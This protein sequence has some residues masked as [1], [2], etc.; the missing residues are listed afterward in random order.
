MIDLK[1]FLSAITQIEEEK[2]IPREKIIET[3][4]MALAA[5]YKKDYGQRG[6]IIRAKLDPE[7]GDFKLWQ[8]KIVV[9]ESM[10]KSEE[11]IEQE[12]K[13]GKVQEP[14]EF[15]SQE[16]DEELPKK[17]RFNEE[18]HIMIDEARTI[19]K[20]AKPADELIFDVQI[21]ED[22]GR[23]AAQ[24]AKQ[25]IIQRIREAER[26]AVYEEY[27][28]KADQIISGIV[29]RIEGS[30][31]FF[32]IGKTTGVM[33]PKDRM[34]NEH[35]RVGQ[36]LRL[37]LLAIEQGPKGAIIY[38][39]RSHPKMLSRLFELEV[40]EI[41]AETVIIKAIAREAGARSK[42]AVTS[43]EEGV[44]PIGSCV[45]QRGTRVTAVIQEL[46]GEKIDII[47]WHEDSEEFIAASLSPAKVLGVELDT[48]RARVMVSEDQ[49]SLAIGKDGQ[50]VRLAAKLTG[51]RIDIVSKETGEVEQG[52]KPAEG[53]ST[54]GEEEEPSGQEG[55]KKK[56]TIIK[57]KAIKKED[58]KGASAT[59][60]KESTKKKEEPKKK[61]SSAKE[62]GE[63]KPKKKI[64]KK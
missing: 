15:L 41:S 47:E 55:T 43:T 58:E 25:V 62:K 9:D 28:E 10:I 36:R 30:Y 8:V 53:E 22:F 26:E 56:K 5:A 27:A 49:L 31:V 29:Q 64:K 44:D 18:K 54:S 51:W 63:K 20:K 37:Y 35:Y 40:P 59:Q 17:V 61:K 11:E 23:I 14:E 33:M 50:N 24:T 16:G 34:P 12:I 42:I 7:T 3:V 39:S 46:G 13:E 38:V 45:G 4:E 21:H 1:N 57:K 60:K 2:G 32:D 6:Q 52:V 48:N 19:N